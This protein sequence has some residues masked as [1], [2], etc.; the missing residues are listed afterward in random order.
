MNKDENRRFIRKSESLVKPQDITTISFLGDFNKFLPKKTQ[1]NIMLKGS[2]KIPYMGFIIDPYC[3]FLSYRI[4]N[5]SAA[6][7][8]LPDGYELAEA[9]VFKNEQKYP[10]VIVS[11][12]S[13][14]TSAFIGMRL[15]FYII[16]RSKETGLLSWIISDYETNTNSHDPKNGFCGYTSDPAVFTTT[17]YGELLIDFKGRRNNKEFSVCTDLKSGDLGNLDESLWVEGNLSVDYGGELKDE[18][19]KPFSLIFDPVLMKEAIKIPIENVDIKENSYLT[20]II[21]HDKP[22]NAVIFPYSQH[23]VIK[24]DLKKNDLSNETELNHQIRSFLSRTGFKTMSGD[25]IKKPL[26]KGMLIS[27]LLNIGLILF[28][29]IKLLS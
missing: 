5:T 17:P 24:Q 29:L 4:S 1:H 21:D 14:R 10:M 25:D 3:F 13:A 2:R 11:A 12:F 27:S 6:Q 23:F 18:S 9:S 16:A 26:F 20:S 19:S 22:L 28:L 8:M 7:A 15:E